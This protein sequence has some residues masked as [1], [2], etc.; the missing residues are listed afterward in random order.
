[1]EQKESMGHAQQ[2]TH[3]Q[4]Y[5]PKKWTGMSFCVIEILFFH[6]HSYL[7]AELLRMVPVS[8]WP[9]NFSCLYCDFRTFVYRNE[10][11]VD[12]GWAQPSAHG[13]D[14]FVPRILCKNSSVFILN[15]KLL[16]FLLFLIIWQTPPWT[17]NDRQ[18]IKIHG[19]CFWFSV[20]AC[21]GL[22]LQQ[23]NTANV[24]RLSKGWL[25]IFAD[26]LMTFCV[27]LRWKSRDPFYEKFT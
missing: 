2:R 11:C 6:P 12:S 14:I 5:I 9:L 21:F 27:V 16:Y 13:T 19:Q 4:N 1:M 8:F 7:W 22:S 18:P 10:S 20:L 26:S 23:L 3:G 15:T 17:L 25:Y 24:Q